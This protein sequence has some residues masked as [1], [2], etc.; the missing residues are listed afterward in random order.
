MNATYLVPA[1]VPEALA[2]A[3]ANRESFAYLAGGT[4]L[5]VHRQQENNTAT[6]LIDLSALPGFD[7]IE[8]KNGKIL[9]GAGVTLHELANAETVLRH[10]PLL[11]EAAQSIASPV[12]RKSATVGG[13]L[14]VENRCSF[15]NQSEF[16]REAIGLCLKCGGDV[17]IATGG[18]KAC[19]SVFVSDLVPALICLGAKVQYAV[20]D[21]MFDMPLEALYTG[22]GLN[23]L[24]LP[25][26]ALI[27]QVEVPVKNGVRTW[28]QKLR[29]RKSVDFTNLTL[30]L[31][32]EP[33]NGRLKVALS[34]VDMG[35]VVFETGDLSDAFVKSV[36]KKCRM[37]ENLFY[38]RAY[39]KKM[40]EVYLRQG[41]KAVGG[42]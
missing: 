42:R 5:M 35:P 10:Y 30:A 14:L 3:D 4:D 34:G 37:V 6:C 11:A 32:F 22:V 33:D 16:W 1:S 13:N 9:I 28:F 36:G 24:H 15:F 18:K 25:A 26:G 23:P 17:C 7:K 40:V 19:Y 41:L 12:I 2:A 38:P 31:S 39:R 8:V 20:A 29:P 27:T 21:G